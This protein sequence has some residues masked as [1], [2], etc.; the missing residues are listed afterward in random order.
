MRSN[1]PGP[2]QAWGNHVES[3]LSNLESSSAS[4]SS[5]LSGLSSQ[6]SSLAK[7]LATVG[8]PTLDGGF[9]RKDQP[10]NIGSL[11]E[12]A[13]LSFAWPDNANSAMVFVSAGIL[14]NENW[15]QGY[16]QSAN[17]ALLEV[18]I[19]GTK[20][21][22]GLARVTVLGKPFFMADFSTQLAV[23]RP[24]DSSH[25]VYTNLLAQ[26]SP[27][28]PRVISGDSPITFIEMST[29]ILFL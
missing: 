27:Q 12:F 4:A 15:E 22:R 7:S 10:G 16:N 23:Q 6:V 14:L 3:R 9:F 1:L 19:N 26:G 11:T 17:T 8:R 13:R 28:Y 24:E 25:N 21:R 29:S 18:D 2:S 20:F 5:N